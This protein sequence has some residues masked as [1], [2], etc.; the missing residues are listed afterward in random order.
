F[1]FREEI[2][3]L[4]STLAT[5]S[6]LFETTEWRTQITYKPAVDPDCACSY[7]MGDA[8]S[9]FQVLC[10]D[11]AVQSIICIVRNPQCFFFRIERNNRYN[12]TKNFFLANAGLRIFVQINRRLK[13]IT[14]F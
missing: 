11:H 9:P 7:A 4:L 10:P 13:V 14:F 1:R 6:T 2:Q 5:N 3:T 8:V 12:R